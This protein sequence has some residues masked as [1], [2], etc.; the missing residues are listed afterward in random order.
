[1]SDSP[2]EEKDGNE[3][4]IMLKVVGQ[5]AAQEVQFRLKKTSPLYKL[6]RSYAKRA[7]LDLSLV[8]FL[9]D[10]KR[11]ADD[12]TPASLE[13]EDGD[14]IEVKEQQIGGAF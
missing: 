11:I 13:M 1:M 7:N 9:F 10:Q 8:V 6:K 5:D 4:H 2:K 12:D 14:I 3:D